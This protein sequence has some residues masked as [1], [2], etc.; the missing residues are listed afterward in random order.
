MLRRLDLLLRD[1][2][3]DALPVLASDD[4]VRFQPPDATLR[5]DVLN[6]N[7]LALDVYLVELRE[8]RK[9]RTNERS[10]VFED[11]FVHLEP[12]PAL[13]DC[14][15]LI[16][17]WSPAQPALEP[18]LDEHALL[19]EAAAVLFQNAP[20]NPSRVYPPGA[21]AL[22]AWPE[23]FRRTDL[24]TALLPPEGFAKL[25]EFW[26]T[27][28]QDSRWKPVLHL[29]VTLPVV[30]VRELAGFMVTTRITDY[31][32]AG[33][34]ETAE[35]W[36]Q[37]GGHVLTRNPQP[38]EPPL[39]VAGAWVEIEPAA[40]GVTRRTRTNALGRFTFGRLRADR[41]RLHTVAAGLGALDREVDVPTE[42]GEYNL[43]LP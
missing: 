41:Y 40:G 27:M 28:G 36:M 5:A 18:A 17:A 25:S 11:G 3:R 32:I 22:A 2:L 9:L 13:V 30:L 33:L 8:N 37:I 31:R 42:T 15:Y 35:V 10:P 29:V 34:R 16:S 7:D 1:V 20:L 23:R 26:T 39:A 14:H 21:P 24:P 43:L 4:Q 12:A 6:L 38:G 19:Y